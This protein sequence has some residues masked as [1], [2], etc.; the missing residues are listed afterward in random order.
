MYG[1]KWKRQA[2]LL[3]LTDSRQLR[4]SAKSQNLYYPHNLCQT[5]VTLPSTLSRHSLPLPPTSTRYNVTKMTNPTSNSPVPMMTSPS[6]QC[7]NSVSSPPLPSIA[8]VRRSHSAPLMKLSPTQHTQQ[9]SPS[10]RPPPQ[11]STLNPPLSSRP[12]TTSA[13]SVSVSSIGA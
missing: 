2:I 3:W 13:P 4:S 6:P 10:R 9:P 12:T 7:Q 1:D 8:A 11:P 5:P